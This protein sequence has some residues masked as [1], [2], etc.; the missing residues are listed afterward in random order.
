MVQTEAALVRSAS[1]MWAAF[2][3]VYVVEFRHL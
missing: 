3:E 1:V 2:D